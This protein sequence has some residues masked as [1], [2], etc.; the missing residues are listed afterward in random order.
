MTPLVT[1][2]QDAKRS[3]YIRFVCELSKPSEQKHEYRG[4]NIGSFVQRFTGAFGLLLVLSFPISYSIEMK[5]DVF[6]F[7]KEC[8]V[9]VDFYTYDGHYILPINQGDAYVLN[10]NSKTWITFLP[11]YKMQFRDR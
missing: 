10:E 11:D 4:P 6:Y 1:I 7:V 5:N 9:A 2:W 3:D 8:I